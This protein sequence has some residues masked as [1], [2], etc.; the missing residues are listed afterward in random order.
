M[1]FLLSKFSCVERRKE[2]DQKVGVLSARERHITGS[3][4]LLAVSVSD[5][6]PSCM[7]EEE[8]EATD[9]RDLTTLTK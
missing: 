6:T 9:F 2:A 1:E 7:E 3:E 4:R 5:I 8:E